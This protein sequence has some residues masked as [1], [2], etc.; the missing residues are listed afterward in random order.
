MYWMH[1][2]YVLREEQLNE[3]VRHAIDK[4]ARDVESESTCLEVFSKI[5]FKPHDRIFIARQNLKGTEKISQDKIPVDTAPML[6]FWNRDSALAHDQSFIFSRPGTVQIVMKYKVS[7]GDTSPAALAKYVDIDTSKINRRNYKDR[8]SDNFP[9]ERHI[10][11]HFLD[12]VLYMYLRAE[13]INEKMFYGIINPKNKVE[14]ASQGASNT[15]VMKASLS[16]SIFDDKYFTRPYRLG[17]YFDNKSY[18]IAK[19]L[20]GIMLVSTLILGILSYAFLSFISTINR[21]KKLSEM[22]TDFINNMTH[23]F[24]TPITNI[25]LAIETMQESG[26]LNGHTPLLKIIDQENHRLQENVEKIL[27][28]ATMD[29][30]DYQLQYERF[31]LHTLIMDISAHILMNDADKKIHVHYELE[32]IY[33]DLEADRTHIVNVIYNLMDNAVKYSPDGPDITIR[34]YNK[35]DGIVVIIADKGIGMNEETLKRAFDK[36]YRAHTGNIHDVKGFG[37][38]L[39]YVKSITDRHNGYISVNSEL[40]KGSSFELYL[41]LL[42][43]CEKTLIK[44]RVW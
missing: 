32:A 21:Q 22:K 30:E 19:S 10:S 37:L 33:H 15:R 3:K 17:I 38:G 7:P 34:T 29:K 14:F 41:P 2:A 23:E 43:Q 26:H 28:L 5:N 36:F 6:Y 9:H 42:A 11:T 35:E 24:K 18:L 44:Q 20:V 16:T 12:S 40:G 1:T 4:T 27:Q 25:A 39:S 31:D 13:G 8:I